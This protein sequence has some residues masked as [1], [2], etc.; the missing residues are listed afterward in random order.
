MPYVLD[1]VN[2]QIT[3]SVEAA[4]RANGI[5]CKGKAVLLASLIRAIGYDTRMVTTDDKHIYVEWE[6]PES[7]DWIA[8]DAVLSTVADDPHVGDNAASSSRS[9]VN[10][11]DVDC[12]GSVSIACTAPLDFSSTACRASDYF[13]K[14]D[15]LSNRADGSGIAFQDLS[16]TGGLSVTAKDAAKMTIKVA[17]EYTRQ[18]KLASKSRSTIPIFPQPPRRQRWTSRTWSPDGA[19]SVACR[20]T[21]DV[22]AGSVAAS[23]LFLKFNGIKGQSVAESTS[24]SDITLSGGLSV[25]SSATQTLSAE[26]VKFKWDTISLSD[27]ANGRSSVTLDNASADGALNISSTSPANVALS[28]V[29]ASD[30][31][32]K[33]D[34]IKGESLVE[35]TSL[36]DIT[37]T[38]GLSVTTTAAQD[39]SVSSARFN[40]GKIE[41][42]AVDQGRST[43]AIGDLDGD[44][45][46]DFAASSPANVTASGVRPAISTS[47]STASRGRAW[48]NHEPERHYPQRRVVRQPAAPRKPCPPSTSSSS[49]TRSRSATR[50]TAAPA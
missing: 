9:T 22:S 40:F 41:I 27:A 15:N 35:N 47:S 1:P 24:L 25:T 16:L 3:P 48:P 31:F 19:L 2:V 18:I 46:L 5:D 50:R 6:N 28:S 4:M 49:G 36:S 44:G 21:F 30:I 38:G 10:E 13:L 12:G 7:G 43:V 26:H 32:L 45:R 17:P 34:G 11:T 29:Q 39:L 20:G 33:L 23:D 42:K 8:A 37:L 14:I